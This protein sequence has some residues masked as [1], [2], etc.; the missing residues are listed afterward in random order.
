MKGLEMYIHR[1]LASAMKAGQVDPF[2]L[3]DEGGWKERKIR[4]SIKNKVE[5]ALTFGD[6]VV[7]TLTPEDLIQMRDILDMTIKARV[8][9]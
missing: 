3:V 2:L 7:I 4:L 5:P 6:W 1:K 9:Q 8:K